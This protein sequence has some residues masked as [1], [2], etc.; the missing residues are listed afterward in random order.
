MELLG[1]SVSS[2]KGSVFSYSVALLY[3]SHKIRSANIFPLS[4][5]SSTFEYPPT[6]H[7]KTDP[8]LPYLSFLTYLGEQNGGLAARSV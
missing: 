2:S 4:T 7:A 8:G 6:C 5:S 1:F 3:A